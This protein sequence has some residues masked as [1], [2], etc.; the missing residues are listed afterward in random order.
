MKDS[1]I[2]LAWGKKKAENIGI[3]AFA[4]LMEKQK[5]KCNIYLVQI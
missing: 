3:I 5:C 2:Q 4:V 1:V